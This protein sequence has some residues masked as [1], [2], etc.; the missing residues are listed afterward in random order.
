MSP[1]GLEAHRFPGDKARQG[2]IIPSGVMYVIKARLV[3]E[4]RQLNMQGK[5]GAIWGGPRALCE[6]GLGKIDPILR[7]QFCVPPAPL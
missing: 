5:A 7:K 3:A 6:G 1:R 4:R 2:D